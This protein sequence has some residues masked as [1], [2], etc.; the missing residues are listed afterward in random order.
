MHIR[1]VFA[2][3]SI[4]ERKCWSTLFR[5][6]PIGWRPYACIGL[7]SYVP[8][9]IRQRNRTQ[10]VSVFLQLF[11]VCCCCRSS[12][13]RTV[14]GYGLNEV[15]WKKD[16]CN[17]TYD[18]MW[19][20]KREWEMNVNNKC[21]AYDLRTELETANAYTYI[22]C[23]KC[24]CGYSRAASTCTF[25]WVYSLLEICSHIRTPIRRRIIKAISIKQ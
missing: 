20:R 3:F 10:I 13:S 11:C 24:V 14:F 4:Q 16:L 17:G 18:R 8:Y 2:I 22:L 6:Y 12:M 19:I 25:V 23:Y 1:F 21:S 5:K 9:D 15:S 7:M